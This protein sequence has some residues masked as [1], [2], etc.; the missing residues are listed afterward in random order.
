MI[1]PLL[2]AI[3]FL[4]S[5]CAGISKQ[6]K[7]K[8]LS[9]A[10]KMSFKRKKVLGASGKKVM[11]LRAGQWV[12][13]VTKHKGSSGDITIQKMK[14]LKVSRDTVTLEIE[15]WSASGKG[16][17]TTTSYV[18]KN[19]P[20]R[21]NISYQ[22]KDI[23]KMLDDIKFKR[24]ITKTG[25]N[26]AVEVPAPLLALTS[27]FAKNIVVGAHRT[28]KLRT[29]SCQ[30]AKITSRKCYEYSF[31]TN[32]LG[33]NTKGTIT[34]HS[35]IPIMG[36]LKQSTDKFDMEVIAYGTKGATGKLL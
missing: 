18:I 34:A 10:D 35:R 13:S 19:Y 14:V 6:E 4:V 23:D 1:R 20:R 36:I 15:S 11:P 5:S 32:V 7:N 9:M 16:Q 26:R 28:G 22:E 12:T 24:M 3:V 2:V 27:S 29:K 33:I 21:F 31:E 8:I 25:K 30:V 17:E